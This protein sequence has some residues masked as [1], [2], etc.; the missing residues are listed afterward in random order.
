MT[1]EEVIQKL[2]DKGFTV[3]STDITDEDIVISMHP[4]CTLY[5]PSRVSPATLPELAVI[6]A[7]IGMYLGS[8][9]GQHICQKR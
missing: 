8:F 3:K 1:R 9:P 7:G 6:P 4:L 2:T 5:S